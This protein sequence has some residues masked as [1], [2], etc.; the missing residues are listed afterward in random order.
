[1]AFDRVN[2]EIE[3]GGDLYQRLVDATVA[4]MRPYLEKGGHSVETVQ[5]MQDAWWK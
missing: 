3:E 1:M 2:R 5:R 4:P